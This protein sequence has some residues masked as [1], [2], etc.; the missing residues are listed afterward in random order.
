M[1]MMMM[2]MIWWWRYTLV[3]APFCWMWSGAMSL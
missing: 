3:Y 1:M 2:M